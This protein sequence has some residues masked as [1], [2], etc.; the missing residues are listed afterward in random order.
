MLP[1]N[2][3]EILFFFIFT[4]DGCKVDSVSIFQIVKCSDSVPAE[5]LLCSSSQILII[6]PTCLL[7]VDLAASLKQLH[8]HQSGSFSKNP[9]LK[10]KPEKVREIED[11]V[12]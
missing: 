5:G 2:C 3:D 6:L 7:S 10:P 12:K 11:L 8:I 4:C 1:T 9:N